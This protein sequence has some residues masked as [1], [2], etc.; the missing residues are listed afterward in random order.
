MAGGW[1]PFA[2]FGGALPATPKASPKKIP[3]VADNCCLCGRHAAA[4][5]AF[6]MVDGTSGAE[7]VMHKACERRLPTLARDRISAWLAHR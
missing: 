4:G 6:R 7:L 5:D 1:N 3:L 2:P